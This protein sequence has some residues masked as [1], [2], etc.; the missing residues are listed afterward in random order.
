[1]RTV[2]R[3]RAAVARVWVLSEYGHCDVHQ[4]VPLNRILRNA[5]FLTVRDG[6][7]GENVDTFAS[8]AGGL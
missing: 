7:F 5:G 2:A 1:M 4:H 6:P 8:R 3:R